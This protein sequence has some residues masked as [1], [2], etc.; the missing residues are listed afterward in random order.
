M[1]KLFTLLTLALAAFA[2]QAKPCDVT[3]H[4]DD[5]SHADK[6]VFNG[7]TYTFDA[8]GYI[9]FTSS[10]SNGARIYTVDPWVL[11]DKCNYTMDDDIYYEIDCGASNQYYFYI[12]CD[13][14]SKIVYEFKTS[15]VEELR[16]N[17]CTVNVV[18]NPEKVL[19]NLQSWINPRT[20]EDLKE[21]ENIIKYLDTE[22]TFVFA[23][24]D[25]Y[26][27]VYEVYHNGQ[28]HEQAH[29]VWTIEVK[30]GDR[31][32]VYT[33]YPPE[34]VTISIDYK[35]DAS[36]ASIKE[37]MIGGVAVADASQPIVALKG[38]RMSISFNNLNY[39]V[40]DLKVNGEAVEVSDWSASYQC[41]LEQDLNIEVKQTK[42]PVWTANVTVDDYTRIKYLEA[43]TEKTPTSNTFVVEIAQDAADLMPVYFYPSTVDVQI[44]RCTAD[45][46]DATYSELVN[47]YYVAME[48]YVQEI[49][50]TT[51]VIK[52]N[53]TFA[54]YFDDP[55][56]TKDPDLGF[57]GWWMDCDL[58]KRDVNKEIH[59][60]YSIVPFAPIDGEFRFTVFGEKETVKSNVHVYLNNAALDM[61]DAGGY[62]R[63]TPDN[64][65]VM[66]AYISAEAPEF[67]DV[68]FTVVGDNVVKSARVDGVRAIDVVDGLVLSEL[69]ST[70][71]AI[72]LVKG[73]DVKVNGEKVQPGVDGVYSFAV[74]GDTKVWIEEEGA[75]IEDIEA[76]IDANSDVYNMLGVKVSNGDVTNLPAGIY[77]QK[78]RKV[79]VK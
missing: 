25:D 32:D 66:K 74:T 54:F 64:A 21:G 55:E 52:R 19:L 18:G 48:E 31:I 78:G 16:K 68:T 10:E 40:D 6:V 4:I 9:R 30:D 22:Y 51:S 73:Y 14:P 24:T 56:A 43:G 72:S 12:D 36:P 13:V 75:G 45:G 3:I 57:N 65:D 61:F 38:E 67:Y 26:H 1:K 42:K 5:P 8:D 7:N 33:E 59:Q 11:T 60:G 49:V 47:G 23:S 70:S 41:I 62:W 20:I 46:K 15:T 63:I 77:V 79:L 29:N 71:V 44:D 39:I 58:L 2:A 69:P 28:K 53:D 27:P 17:T 35:G 34:D 50:I 76:P 37:F